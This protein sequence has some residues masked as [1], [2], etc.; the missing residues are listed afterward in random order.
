M[1]LLSWNIQWGRGADGV[2]NLSRTIA[3]IR[4]LGNFDVIC[5]Q[6]VSVGFA[7]L[8]GGEPVD[9]VAVLASAFPEYSAHYAEGVDVPDGEGGRSCFGNLTLSRLPVG[10]VFRH[11]LPRPP[12]EGVPS[13]P[14]VCLEV[15]ISGP[16]GPVRVLNTH[17][18][19]YSRVQRMTQVAALSGL[20]CDVVRLASATDANHRETSPDSP[21]ACWPRP[22]SAVVCGD[23]NCEPGSPEYYR[24]TAPVAADVPGWEDAWRVCYGDIPHLATVG[25]NGAEWPD[26]RYCCDFFFISGDLVDR[27]EA[28]AVDQATGAS[29]HQPVMLT[30]G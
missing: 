14:R 9:E 16:R 11:S 17:L 30:L 29:D 4:M 19:Y 28:V 1:R 13:M 26:R 23:F 5:L 27:V 25:L 20:Q 24:M 10:Q 12:D 6:E 22:V 15:V 2:V 7:S 8:H 18:E 3:A 21:F